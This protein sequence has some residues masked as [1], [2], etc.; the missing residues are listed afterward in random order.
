MKQHGETAEQGS[1]STFT[2][3]L[4]F[5]A[6]LLIAVAKSF[7]AAF[8]GS[9][10]MVAEA[11]HSWADAGNE[12]F[13]LVADRRSQR[14]R[15]V[16]HPM[17]Y[18]R[19]AYIWSMFAAFGLFTAGAVVSIMHGVQELFNPEPAGDFLIAYLVLAVSFIL[20]GISFTQ[21]YR[22]ARKTA[23]LMQIPTLEHV[24]NSSNPT[25]RAVFAEDAAALIGL[26]L[27]FLGILLHQIT[28]S[29]IP[30]AIG[31]IAVGVLLGV[32][33]VVLIDRNRRF[34]VGQS[35]SRE[36]EELAVELLLKRPEIDRVTYIHLE[37]VGPSK[38]YLVA[39]VDLQGNRNEDDVALKLRQLER[40][41]E[42]V[43]YIEEA[44]IT[45]STKEEPAL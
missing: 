9:A 15:D 31:S 37:F 30:D 8:T 16:R 10:S 29:P 35:A 14:P 24:A 33:A 4:A 27:A 20:E 36:A 44:V 18:G 5:A 28:G 22:Q 39:A 6:N 43:G 45:L 23:R 26:L 40:E 11:A 41:L 2:V 17:G 12:V 32:I 42:N 34:L 19:E 7:A 13:L 38:L 21:A 1:E 25:L 3:V